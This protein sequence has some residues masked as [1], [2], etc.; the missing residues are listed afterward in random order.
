[1]KN[2]WDKLKIL[3]GFM[4]GLGTLIN[5]VIAVLKYRRNVKDTLKATE[6]LTKVVD[7]SGMEW[8]FPD[9]KNSYY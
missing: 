1:M 5:S 7:D 9:E 8:D 3:G 2:T 4:L 6:E